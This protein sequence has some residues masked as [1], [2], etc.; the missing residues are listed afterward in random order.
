MAK[1]PEQNYDCLSSA[2]GLQTGCYTIA[3]A[4]HIDNNDLE[5]FTKD[6]I[7]NFIMAGGNFLAS[8]EGLETF[9]NVS[10]YQS[11]TGTIVEPSVVVE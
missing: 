8:C 4:P 5:T 1:V 7:Y 2:V 3:T 10:L 11:T 6:S 9:E